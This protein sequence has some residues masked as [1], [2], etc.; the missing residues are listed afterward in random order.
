MSSPVLELRRMRQKKLL[1]GR[2]PFAKRCRIS[3]ETW[4]VGVLVMPSGAVLEGR[5]R[6]LQPKSA[7]LPGITRQRVGLPLKIFRL[8]S[9]L[10][11]LRGEL[12]QGSARSI[13]SR[14]TGCVAVSACTP[15]GGSNGAMAR[16]PR[17]ST[18]CLPW[19]ASGDLARAAK[20][21]LGG[22]GLLATAWGFDSPVFFR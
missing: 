2:P 8:N 10:L 11:L 5:G 6:P 4:R 21:V 18:P 15:Y 17:Q 19:R 3:A 1:S 7:G 22:L 13:R 12:V 16:H 20:G 9:L 14:S